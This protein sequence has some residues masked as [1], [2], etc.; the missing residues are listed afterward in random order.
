MTGINFFTM[1]G[2]AFFLHGLGWAIKK[3]YSE[4]PLAP[5]E[6]RMAFILFGVCLVFTALLYCLTTD[7]KR[8][9]KNRCVL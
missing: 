2:V 6:F 1:T 4:G 5:E 9:L 8:F 7:E 3:F